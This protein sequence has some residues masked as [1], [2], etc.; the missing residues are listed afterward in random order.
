MWVTVGWLGLV[1]FGIF[2]LVAV[3]TLVSLAAAT[4]HGPLTY[5]FNDQSLDWDGWLPD[6]PSSSPSSSAGLS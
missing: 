6:E 1:S 4:Q 5:R 3:A 2:A